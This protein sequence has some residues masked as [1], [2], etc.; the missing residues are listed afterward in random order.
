MQSGVRAYLRMI[1]RVAHCRTHIRSA[2]AHPSR[3][4]ALGRLSASGACST[5][6]SFARSPGCVALVRSVLWFPL[7][8][9]LLAESFE[10][11]H[12]HTHSVLFALGEMRAQCDP[13]GGNALE[14]HS[15]MRGQALVYFCSCGSSCGAEL[16]KGAKHM[17]RFGFGAQVEDITAGPRQRTRCTGSVETMRGGAPALE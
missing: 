6:L 12:T 11:T 2:L 9:V 8:G 4:F 1:R 14:H 15:C 17:H 7:D 13:T 3:G 16:T 5:G 10:N